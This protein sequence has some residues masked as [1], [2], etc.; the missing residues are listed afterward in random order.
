MHVERGKEKRGDEG[1]QGWGG[2][3][4]GQKGTGMGK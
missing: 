1:A 4:R 2:E 3:K